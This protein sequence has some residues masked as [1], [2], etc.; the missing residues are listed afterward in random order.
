MHL[1]RIEHAFPRHDDLLRLL[2]DGQRSNERGDLRGASYSLETVRNGPKLDPRYREMAT[3]RLHEVKAPQH[4]KTRRARLLGRLPPVSY[5]H[6]T[7][8]TKA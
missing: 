5:T 8:P 7:L 4:L 1:E 6:L 2:L 3:S